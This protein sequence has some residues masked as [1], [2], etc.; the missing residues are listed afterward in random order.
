VPNKRTLYVI[1]STSSSCVQTVLDPFDLT[2]FSHTP[3]LYDRFPQTVQVSDPESTNSFCL[4]TL[5]AYLLHSAHVHTHLGLLYINMD[6]HDVDAAHGT[7]PKQQTTCPSDKPSATHEKP[8]SD[9]R[10]TLPFA[11]D[12]TH[13]PEDPLRNSSPPNSEKYDSNS[14]SDTRVGDI[15][16][17]Q[18]ASKRPTNAE[19]S[20]QKKLTTTQAVI[21]FVTNEVGIGMLSLPAALNVLGFFPGLL[22]IIIMGM[23]SL[24]TAYNLI[25]YWRKYPYMLNIVDYGRVLGGPWVEAVFAVGFLINMALI[26]ASALVTLTIGLNTVSEHATCTVVFTVV[27]A[28]AMWAMCVPHSMRFV[29]WA[30]W[31]CTASIIATVLIVMITLGVQGPRDPTAPLNLK[32]IGNPNFTQAV[33]AFLNIAFAYTGN[34]AFPTVLAEMENPSRDFPRAVTIE[35]C[36]TTTIYVIV[37]TTVYALSGEQVASPAIGSLQTTMAKVSYAVSFIGLLGTGLIFGMTSARYLH[38][39]FMR[40]I[41]LITRNKTERRAS[42]ASDPS[43]GHQSTHVM[44]ETSKKTEW[45][46]WI[47]SVTLFWVVVWI[48]ANAIPVFNSLLNISSSLLLSWFTW[49]VTVLF[50][51]HLNWNGRWRSSSKKLATAAFNVSI[52]ILVF[53]MMIPGMYASIDSLM[54]VF[55]DPN[56]Q[57]NGAFTCADNS[58][59]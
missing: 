14:D 55:A 43:R 18:N 2:C 50:W 31:P 48:L 56:Q 54:K 29:S 42:I 9:K 37:A 10:P 20:G 34:Q 1:P 4:V 36:I 8:L 47:F 22:C 21:I 6:R 13:D 32:A 46:V 16:E 49:G 7:L 3:F 28:L 51:F 41:D 57:V 12:A 30:S 24:Y 19:T 27:S 15:S 23:L 40:H 17:I 59:V 38:T 5:P 25:Q 58:I 53:F 52:M 44:P 35:K 33:S 11:A 26:S 39:W 45:A